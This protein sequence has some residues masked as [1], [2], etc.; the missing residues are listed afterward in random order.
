MV[1]ALSLASTMGTITAWQSD[2][3][4]P[5]AQ[6]TDADVAAEVA[7]EAAK[8]GDDGVAVPQTDDS[9]SEAPAPVSASVE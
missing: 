5:G 4:E 1:A 7:A 2:D 6:T 3:S 9:R 8:D